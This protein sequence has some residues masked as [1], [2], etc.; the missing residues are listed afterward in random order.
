MGRRCFAGR[1][2]ASAISPRGR[3]SPYSTAV[4]DPVGNRS[5]P[6]GS[7]GRPEDERRP[8]RRG[9]G[10]GTTS[11]RLER[12]LELIRWGDQ[13]G[14][15]GDQQAVT[16]EKERRHPLSSL[17]PTA[18]LTGQGR[19]DTRAHHER[20]EQTDRPSA[21]A[22]FERHPY[23]RV[24]TLRNRVQR[25]GRCVSLRRALRPQGLSMRC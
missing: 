20:Y 22:G 7:W 24:P 16:L 19:Y 10:T 21:S 11:D 2:T 5:R 6:T 12:D 3:V 25:R 4:I 23:A 15:L 14:T 9:T 8:G 18:G 1:L 13:I 17:L